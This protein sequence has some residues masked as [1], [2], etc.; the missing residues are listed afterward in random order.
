MWPLEAGGA[1][2]SHV[3]DACWTRFAADRNSKQQASLAISLMSTEAQHES[4]I[5]LALPLKVAMLPVR[6]Q[7]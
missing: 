3:C 6:P 2:V 4:S 5:L 7:A 1:L